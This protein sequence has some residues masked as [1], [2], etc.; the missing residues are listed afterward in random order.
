[1]I[2]SHIQTKLLSVN[3]E[4][5]STSLEISI[6]TWESNISSPHLHVCVSP[7]VFTP[8]PPTITTFSNPKKPYFNPYND[9]RS[10]LSKKY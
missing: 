10:S 8:T 1:M 3:K 9:H 4:A 2:R 5:Q 6:G 7:H